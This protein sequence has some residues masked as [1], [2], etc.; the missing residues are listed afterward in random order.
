MDGYLYLLA[1]VGLVGWSA[2]LYLLGRLDGIRQERS[3]SARV[4]RMSER[5]LR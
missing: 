3:R 1:A 5:S 4:R 2:C